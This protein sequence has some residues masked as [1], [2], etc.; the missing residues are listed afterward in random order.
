[1]NGDWPLNRSAISASG[2]GLSQQLQRT[3]ETL[4]VRS[5]PR[6]ARDQILGDE[7]GLRGEAAGEIGVGQMGLS[8][9]HRR[10]EPAVDADLDQTHQCGDVIGNARD[11]LLQR[12][13]RRCPVLPRD[14]CIRRQFDDREAGFGR[15][16]AD[17]PPEERHFFPTVW[18]LL[19]QPAHDR[20]PLLGRRPLGAESR[21]P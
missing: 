18:M 13:G 1:M 19:E 17:G 3:A 20:Q 6:L 8:A 21:P 16:L 2:I 9:V 5:V 11:E 7:A 12:G 10:L 14:G 4:E 15:L